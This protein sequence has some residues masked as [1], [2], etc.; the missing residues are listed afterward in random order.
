MHV[1]VVPPAAPSSHVSSVISKAISHHAVIAV[2]RR[3]F[4]V[5]ATMAVAEPDLQGCDV[6]SYL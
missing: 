3:N 4:L 2:S 1:H 5:L 6:I